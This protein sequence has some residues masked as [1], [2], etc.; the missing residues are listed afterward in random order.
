[1]VERKIGIRNLPQAIIGKVSGELLL[2]TTK[3]EIDDPNNSVTAAKE[4]LTTGPLIIIFTHTK[5]DYKVIG[6]FVKHITPLDQAAVVVAQQYLASNR[7]IKRRVMGD[8]MRSW[9]MGLGVKMLPTV[10]EYD[11]ENNPDANAINFRSTRD[12]LEFL[13]TP[14]HVLAIAPTAHRDVFELSRAAEG[15][16][17]ILKKVKPN[18]RILP[19]AVVPSS[20]EPGVITKVSVGELLSPQDIED[21]RAQIFGDAETEGK[22]KLDLKHEHNQ[23]IADTIMYQAAQLLPYQNRGFY[24]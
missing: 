2:A 14:G 11:R 13:D 23:Q 4:H 6:Q 24:R 21:K 16:G 1:M 15:V 3:I 18:T 22:T 7:G 9:E 19:I 10:Q 8:I 5:S 20:I 12:T 17:G